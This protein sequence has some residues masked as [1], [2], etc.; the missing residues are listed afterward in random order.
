MRNLTLIVK[1]HALAGQRKGVYGFEI[2]DDGKIVHEE[3]NV[4]HDG[5]VNYS[6]SDG[7]ASVFELERYK[8]QYQLELA[9]IEDGLRHIAYNLDFVPNVITIESNNPAT[10]RKVSDLDEFGELDYEGVKVFKRGSSA[11]QG[12]LAKKGEEPFL[13]AYSQEIKTIMYETFN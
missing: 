7:G 6:W 12:S 13:D 1:S 2:I 3:H 5:I 4:S 9:A 10:V 11:L 8:E